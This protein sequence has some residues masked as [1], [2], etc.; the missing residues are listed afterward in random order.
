MFLRKRIF[1]CELH[2]NLQAQERGSIRVAEVK[3]MLLKSLICQFVAL[4]VVSLKCKTL[5][6]NPQIQQRFVCLTLLFG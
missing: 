2:A 3:M 4:K 1:R 5:A 6:T